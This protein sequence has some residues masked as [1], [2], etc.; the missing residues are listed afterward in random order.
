[1]QSTFIA[2]TCQCTLRL[3]L[4]LVRLPV[5]TFASVSF[6]PQMQINA[7]TISRTY[8]RENEEYISPWSFSI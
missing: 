5:Q 7:I 2:L 8:L 4:K 6:S 3:P 1:M